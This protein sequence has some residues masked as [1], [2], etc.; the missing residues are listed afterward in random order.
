MNE[1]LKRK[2][3][4]EEG[5]TSGEVNFGKPKVRHTFKDVSSDENIWELSFKNYAPESKKKMRW[6][7]Q[8]YNDWRNDRIRG[9]QV[10]FQII[11]CDFN[12]VH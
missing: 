1:G 9:Q 7:M 10:P 11:R 4:V 12:E 5:E 2:R 6:A 8:S 3:E